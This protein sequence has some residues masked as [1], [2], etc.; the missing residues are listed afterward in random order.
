MKR[1]PSARLGKGVGE[2]FP[3]LGVEGNGGMDLCF[4]PCLKQ[5]PCHQKHMLYI[6]FLFCV[7][8]VFSKT[9]KWI[10]YYCVW[11]YSKLWLLFVKG[12]T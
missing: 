5:I 1:I 8:I 4:S 9:D 2:G 3:G 11:S 7:F 6:F 12:E 10:E